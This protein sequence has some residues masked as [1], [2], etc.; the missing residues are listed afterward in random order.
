MKKIKYRAV[1]KGFWNW[2]ADLYRG[3]EIVGDITFGFWGK[4]AEVSFEGAHYKM[5]RISL[6]KGT[7]EMTLDGKRVAAAKRANSF[8]RTHK[9]VSGD[10]KYELRAESVF[11]REMSLY[12]GSKRL[13]S[14]APEGLLTRKL[15]FEVS[16]S[17][18]PS[19]VA[20][21]TCLVI[22]LWKQQSQAAAS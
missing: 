17:L 20:F 3:R 6:W 9:I 12:R 10:D 2:H 16:E 21:L 4:K 8:S 15:A 11:A 22:T 19:V 7:Y 5:E 13:G 14:W 18:E 1:P